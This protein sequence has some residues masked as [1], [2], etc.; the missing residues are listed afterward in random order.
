VS[1]K[2]C[3]RWDSNTP[4]VPKYKP[5]DYPESGLD[6]NY[7]RNPNESGE[8][9]WCY[10][11]DSRTRWENCSPRGAEDVVMMRNPWGVTEYRSEWRNSDGRWNDELV[12]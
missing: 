11:T 4:H 6:E 7:C 5:Q 8:T 9:L 12:K 10:T 2:T 1:G 3:Q